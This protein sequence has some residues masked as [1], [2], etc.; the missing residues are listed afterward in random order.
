MDMICYYE[1]GAPV[2]AS[3]ALARA[4]EGTRTAEVCPRCGHEAEIPVIGGPCDA[5]GH[6]IRPCSMCDQSINRCDSCPYG[7]FAP[8]GGVR[9]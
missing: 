3:D 9:A 4:Q 2:R 1:D 7:R 6:W 8:A 5:C